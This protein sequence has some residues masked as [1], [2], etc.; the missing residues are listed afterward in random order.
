MSVPIEKTVIVIPQRTVRIVFNR[1]Y[2]DVPTITAIDE[3]ITDSRST[4]AGEMTATYDG[5]N[6]LDVA[7][8]AALEAKIL[9]MRTIRDT[10]LVIEE[11]TDGN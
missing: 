11:V 1:P 9:E 3:V 2:G 10:P 8:Y 7:L 5:T 4:E 6:P